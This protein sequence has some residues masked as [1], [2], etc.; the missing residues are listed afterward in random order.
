MP[1]PVHPA[2]PAAFYQVN[3]AQA[4]RLYEAALEYAQLDKTK[5][6]LDLYCG[7]GTITLALAREAKTVIGAEII[8]QAVKNAKETLIPDIITIVQEDGADQFIILDAK[9]YNIQLEK[10][11]VLRGNPGVGD[12]TKQY[13]YQ[14][15]YRDFMSDHNITVVKNSF[16]MPTEKDDFVAKGTA[17]MEMLEALGLEN[18]QIRLLPAKKIFECY[19][20]RKRIPIAELTL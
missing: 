18:I 16:L 12:V 13:L 14:L 19:L 1:F 3:R 4:E 9:Y 8:P 20:T 15:A 7:A 5:T 17:K 10:D 6:A 2:D 11:K